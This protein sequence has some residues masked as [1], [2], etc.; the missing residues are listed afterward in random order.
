MGPSCIENRGRG[1]LALTQDVTL[2]E[3][4]KA[5]YGVVVR[6]NDECTGKGN[7]TLRGMGSDLTLFPEMFCV[8]IQQSSLADQNVQCVIKTNFK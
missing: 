8:V 7:K 3:R 4:N 6:H 2:G 1:G 5:P